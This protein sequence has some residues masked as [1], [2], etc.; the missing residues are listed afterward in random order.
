MYVINFNKLNKLKNFIRYNL[1]D[2]VGLKN[3]LA[4]LY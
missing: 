1:I 2:D 3:L 4:N